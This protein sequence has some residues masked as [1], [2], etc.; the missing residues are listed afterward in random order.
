MIWTNKFARLTLGG[1]IPGGPGS[2]KGSA[3]RLK[4]EANW[5]ILWEDSS[6][7]S[8]E[9]LSSVTRSTEIE[10]GFDIPNHWYRY[11]WIGDQK[12]K[13][14]YLFTYGSNRMDFCMQDMGNR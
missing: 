14:R 9:R 4:F 11:Y 13:I 2:D 7:A 1:I 3:L 12:K 10:Q 8:D 5:F 6:M